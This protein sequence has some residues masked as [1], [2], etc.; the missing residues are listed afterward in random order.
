MPTDRRADQSLFALNGL[1]GV[2]V[3]VVRVMEGAP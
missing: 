2:A 1:S 3:V